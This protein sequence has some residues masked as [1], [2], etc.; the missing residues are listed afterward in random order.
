LV[1]TLWINVKIDKQLEFIELPPVPKSIPRGSAGI[2]YFMD[3]NDRVL[4]VGE[5]KDAYARVVQ[6]LLGKGKSAKFYK[7]IVRMFFFETYV[8][9][10]LRKVWEGLLIEKWNPPYNVDDEE[11]RTVMG[12][13]DIKNKIGQKEFNE[14]RKLLE[15]G[16]YTQKFISQMYQVGPAK[17]SNIN[18]L[19]NPIYRE[20]EELRTKGMILELV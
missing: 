13:G 14:I 19:V 8:S 10:N 3:K 16:L 6:H 1:N 18:N 20:W 7:Q 4:Y 9:C 15:T 11:L 2:Y 12:R 5:S 17:I